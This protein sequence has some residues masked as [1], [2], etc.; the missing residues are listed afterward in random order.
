MASGK[1]SLIPLLSGNAGCMVCENVKR[2]ALQGAIVNV[3]PLML[4]PI[5]NADQ[6]VEHF[7]AKFKCNVQNDI[8]P[9]PSV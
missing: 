4:Q 8:L 2:F 5:D 6:A 9:S 3:E 7:K 1:A